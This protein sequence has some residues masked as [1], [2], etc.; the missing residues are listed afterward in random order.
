MKERLQG[1]SGVCG[2]IH[3]VRE[4]AAAPLGRAL[5]SERQA[6]VGGASRSALQGGCCPQRAAMVKARGGQGPAAS[7]PQ[8]GGRCD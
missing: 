7:T 3:R 5:S 8:R 4:A 6:A 1:P 2:W